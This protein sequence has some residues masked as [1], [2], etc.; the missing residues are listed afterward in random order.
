MEDQTADYLG[1]VGL[2]LSPRTPLS[3]L[4][5][6]QQ[7]M[8]EIAKALSQNARF[9]I[10]DEPTSS[11]TAGETE[12]LIEIT[13]ELRTRGV[14]VVYV[15]H[16][17]PEV[18]RL[19]DRVVVLRDGCNA[20]RLKQSDAAEGE[21]ANPLTS[22]TTENMVRLM[23]GR[24]IL[25][26]SSRTEGVG[27]CV[28]SVEALCTPR[29]PAHP[30]SLDVHA[31]EIVGLAGLVGAGRTE[32]ARSIFG[33]DERTGTVRVEG[34]PLPPSRIDRSI[35]AGLFLAPE[36]RRSEGL[37]T[38]MS[39]REN[40]TLP[41]VSALSYA[42]LIRNSREQALA[43]KMN[44]RLHVKTPTVEMPASALSGGNQQKVVLAKWLA[45][46]PKVMIF[47]EPTRGIDIGARAE[48]YE[49][50][51]GLAREQVAILMISSDMEEVLAMSD[52][53][54]VLHEGR[55]S[56]ELL[57]AQASEEAVMRLAVG[58]A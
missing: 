25:P 53:I 40:V 30:I 46:K 15:S 57:R 54:L 47:D 32:I 50:M 48:I 12:R 29:F 16:R 31:G 58:S 9:L 19:A 2:K 18:K 49:L 39:I 37:I 23:V 11:L 13:Q 33:V 26:A 44:E 34:V 1:R 55:I 36:D 51:A 5:I 14:G 27:E 21:P 3:R 43:L 35:S 8:V 38:S 42:G 7:Q 4:S 24:D 56:G 17:L 22:I 41:Q 28:L 10:M 45:M 6:A 52:R 20:G